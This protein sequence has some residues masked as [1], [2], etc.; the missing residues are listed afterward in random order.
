MEARTIEPGDECPAG[1][2]EIVEGPA[3]DDG[4][5]E[6]G[7][8]TE[9]NVVC[10]GEDGEDG[11]EVAVETESVSPGDECTA[12]GKEI[13]MGYANEDGELDEEDIDETVVLCHGED[14]PLLL[15]ATEEAE[16]DACPESGELIEYGYDLNDDGELSEDETEGS[17]TVCDGETGAD[18]DTPLVETSAVDPGDDCETGGVAYETGFDTDDDGEI[19]DVESSETICNGE[20]GPAGEPALI[21]TSDISEGST[22][23]AGGVE[24]TY[25]TDTDGDGDIDN[26]QGTEEVCNG[27]DAD[28]IIYS[29]SSADSSDCPAGG[30]E[31]EY[32]YD[33]DDDGEI[34]DSEGSDVICDGQDGQDGED[35]ED[36][37]DGDSGLIEVDT[38]SSGSSACPAGGLELTFGVDTTGDGNID[39]N[40]M[41]QTVCNG[42]DGEDGEDGQDGEDGEDG[43]STAV[44]TTT[45][46]TGDSDCPNGGV[47]AT[48][49]LDTDGDGSVDQTTSVTDICNGEDGDDGEDAQ[50]SAG[51]T[52]VDEND[53]EVGT[54]TRVT[55][56]NVT[57][58]TDDGYVV[59]LQWDGSIAAEFAL[60][61]PNTGCTGT[62]VLSLYDTTFSSVYGKTAVYDAYNDDLYRPKSI[63][64]TGIAHQ[65][66][67]GSVA[68]YA[69]EDGGSC[70]D[71]PVTTDGI[72][73]ES[74]TRT[75]LGLP[76]SETDLSID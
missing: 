32:G 76:S 46:P 60:E 72:E 40:E 26:E 54:A 73:L 6:E 65:N 36:G 71:D 11:R 24:I 70:N 74:A 8:E 22:C 17:Y 42:E 39:S 49:G 50:G 67:N 18:G 3:A 9:T 43:D 30:V 58:L 63:S 10:D 59:T 69:T 64:S 52:I 23:P 53:D 55:A 29:S 7:E 51:D 47:E 68:S 21:E 12:G 15:I 48:F 37:E 62:P 5:V 35:G 19:D 41:T 2:V 25:G 20:T 75:D 31:I 57:V 66:F 1:G 33:T 45:I 34:D 14:A 56:E 13:N 38:L 28:P 16:E 61:F 44:D 27:E 4:T